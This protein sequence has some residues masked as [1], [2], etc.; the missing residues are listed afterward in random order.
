MQEVFIKCHFSDSHYI[1]NKGTVKTS[2]KGYI[3]RYKTNV[4][5]GMIKS[6]GYKMYWIG[7]RFYYAHRL[8]AMH[9][10]PNIDNKPE[11]NHIDG[12]KLNNYKA[13]LE[14]CTHRENHKHRFEVLGHTMPKGAGHWLTGLSPSNETRAKMAAKKIGENHPRFKGWYVL[15]GVRYASSAD[16]ARGRY[17]SGK[18]II[19]KSMNNIDGWSFEPK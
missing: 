1:G 6:N 9:F 12:N 15:N 4:M 13:N 14:W 16:A 18:T 2:S 3:S 5:T 11:V 19:N 10:I 8:V 17:T 7:K